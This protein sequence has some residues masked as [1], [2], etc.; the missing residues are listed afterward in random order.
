M[1]VSRA[2]IARAVVVGAALLA[3]PAPPRHSPASAHA[4]LLKAQKGPTRDGIGRSETFPAEEY[5]GEKS[6]FAVAAAGGDS[7]DERLAAGDGPKTVRVS[8][9]TFSGGHCE[10]LLE[11][12]AAGGSGAVVADLLA[13]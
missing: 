12:G 7:S 4:R 6:L 10:A 9:S 2:T 5:T 3:S 8:L 13:A 1:P 11:C